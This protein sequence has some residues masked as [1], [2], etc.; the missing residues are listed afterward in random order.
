[1]SSP[2]RK[3]R[4]GGLTQVVKC[5][6]SKCILLPLKRRRKSRRRRRRR[7][8]RGKK[9]GGGEEKGKEKK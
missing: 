3:L 7:G 4:A 2:I 6:P 1:L 8:E 5:L 9:E